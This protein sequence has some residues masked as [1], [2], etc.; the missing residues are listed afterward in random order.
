[1]QRPALLARDCRS[2][3]VACLGRR[4]GLPVYRG[5]HSPWRKGR[6]RTKRVSQSQGRSS[7]LCRPLVS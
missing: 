5:P 1:L 7:R 6:K 4:L 3:L 2:S